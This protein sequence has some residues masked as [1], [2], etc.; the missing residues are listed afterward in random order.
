MDNSGVPK[1]T[2]S[3]LHEVIRTRHLMMFQDLNIKHDWYYWNMF[4]NVWNHHNLLSTSSF[5]SVKPLILVGQHLFFFLHMINSDW[6]ILISI[7]NQY[8]E[9]PCLNHIFGYSWCFTAGFY[10]HL[11]P[12]CPPCPPRPRRLRRRK[13]RLRQRRLRRRRPRRRRRRKR[14][15][16]RCRRSRS[17]RSRRKRRRT[18]SWAVQRCS[19]II[20]LC[21]CITYTYIYIYISICVCVF[22]WFISY[23]IILYIYIYQYIT[24]ITTCISLVHFPMVCDLSHFVRTS[25]SQRRRRSK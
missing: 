1:K 11:N 5:F 24:G 21:I 25:N 10:A 23:I 2:L 13:R 15:R 3:R 9:P 7:L 6:T 18:R 22:I 17:R 19:G 20:I 16:R 12:R 8:I 4:E 14:R